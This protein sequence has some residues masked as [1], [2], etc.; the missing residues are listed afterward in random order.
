MKANLR[1]KVRIFTAPSMAL[2]SRELTLDL[3]SNATV[4]DLLNLIPVNDKNY[5]YVVRDGI[6]LNS[7]SRLNDG[8]EILIV[9]P[10]A[11]G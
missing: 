8:D 2:E 9:P 7:T 5:V 11:G 6:R 4:E 3:E 1:V 10:I